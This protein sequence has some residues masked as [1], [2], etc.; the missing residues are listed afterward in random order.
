MQKIDINNL[1]PADLFA[2]IRKHKLQRINY[3]DG[4]VGFRSNDADFAVK[5]FTAISA[6][7]LWATQ[8]NE[9]LDLVDF[10][11]NLADEYEDESKCRK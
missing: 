4:K 3:P 2:L 1:K 6:I 11:D 8:Y 10:F 5:S 7:R 9:L